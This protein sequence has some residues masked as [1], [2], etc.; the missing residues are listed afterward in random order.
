MGK[1]QNTP[2]LA[3]GM[4]GKRGLEAAAPILAFSLEDAPQLAAGFF[5]C[6][7]YMTPNNYAIVEKR[8]ALAVQVWISI[9]Y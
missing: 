6:P 5:T 4:N 8:L 9:N 7:K 3:V 2:Q 1:S